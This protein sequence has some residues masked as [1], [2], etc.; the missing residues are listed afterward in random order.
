MIPIPPSHWVRLRPKRIP[1]GSSSMFS[2]MEEPVVVNHDRVS[3]KDWDWS[4]ID[5][6][7][8]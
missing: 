3:K 7:V 5:S 4:G 2:S 6:M 8:T 1:W